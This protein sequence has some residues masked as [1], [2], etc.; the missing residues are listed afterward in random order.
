MAY[1]KF[2]LVNSL[3]DEYHLTDKNFKHFL[4]SPSGFGMTKSI[5]GTRVGNRIKVNKRI[6][7]IPRPSG[8]L[9]FYDDTNEDKYDAYADFVKFAQFTPL[10]LYYFI[11]SDERTQEEANTVY[12]ECEVMSLSKSEISHNGDLLRVPINFQGETFW[13]SDKLNELIISNEVED[14]GTFTFPLT[15]PFAFGTDPFRN[16]ELNSN[17]TIVTPVTFTIEGECNDPMINFYEKK[18]ENGIEVYDP[19]AACKFEGTYDYVF[20]DANDNNETIT[21]RYNGVSIT[22]PASKQDLTIADPDNE[23]FFMTFMKIKP[24]KTFATF[25]L[26]ADFRGTVTLSWRDEFVSI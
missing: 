17:G 16:I 26:G 24:G 21:L 7:D 1:R 4:N 5:D 11:P 3:G 15:F 20:V 22:N 2:K 8:E 10:R 6:Y 18:I 12:I 14:V 19:Y 9:I 25:S 13:L 23:D